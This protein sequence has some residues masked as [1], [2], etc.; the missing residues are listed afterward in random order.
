MKTLVAVIATILLTVAFECVYQWL[1]A[2]FSG[3]QGYPETMEQSM[4]DGCQTSL[5]MVAIGVFSGAVVWG[6]SLTLGI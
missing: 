2:K 6:I 4:N 1:S 5:R 3:T